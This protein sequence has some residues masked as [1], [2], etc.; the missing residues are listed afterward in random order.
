MKLK[1]APPPWIL[2]ALTFLLL[3]VSEW[4]APGAATPK[5]PRKVSESRRH[6]V[7]QSGVPSDGDWVLVLDDSGRNFPEL[8]LKL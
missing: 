3:M 1:S 4:I 7:D 6:F 5:F 2:A 8:D